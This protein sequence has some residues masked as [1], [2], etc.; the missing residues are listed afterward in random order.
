M[1]AW[2][3]RGNEAGHMMYVAGHSIVANARLS[4]CPPTY[5]DLKTVACRYT[6]R[7]LK[8]MV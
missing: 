5:L 7:T 1:K 6:C 3:W 2:D 4:G 8:R